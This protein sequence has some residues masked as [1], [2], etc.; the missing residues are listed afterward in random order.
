[1]SH[2]C[3]SDARRPGLRSLRRRRRGLRAALYW[4]RTSGSSRCTAIS[5]CPGAEVAIGRNLLA[6]G[7]A[8]PDGFLDYPTLI[9]VSAKP[10]CRPGR[11]RSPTSRPPSAPPATASSPSTDTPPLDCRHPQDGKERESGERRDRARSPPEPRRVGR[12]ARG[13]VTPLRARRG[14]PAGVA[15]PGFAASTSHGPHRR[16]AGS[17]APRRADRTGGLRSRGGRQ[18]PPDG[19]GS[20]RRRGAGRPRRRQP[21]AA[22]RRRCAPGGRDRVARHRPDRSGDQAWRS[23][24]KP[25]SRTTGWWTWTRRSRSPPTCS[26]TV[27]TRWS[28]REA[29]PSISGVRRR[30]GWTSTACGAGSPAG[31][32]PGRRVAAG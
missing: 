16:R 3:R 31:A 23:T 2:G 19:Q 26:S 17:S 14:D 8:D 24:R 27:R 1:M 13:H 15:A 32:Q 29:G 21:A 30:S 18:L 22:P 6:G 12:A 25:A 11:L 4:Q 9:E 10:G 28:P 7:D 20:G 5:A